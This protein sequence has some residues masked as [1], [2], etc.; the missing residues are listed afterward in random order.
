MKFYKNCK[1]E[2]NKFL[3]DIEDPKTKDEVKT[4]Y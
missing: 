2:K 3:K 4:T 1:I